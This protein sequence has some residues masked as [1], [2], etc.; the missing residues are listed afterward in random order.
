MDVTTT[1][2]RQGKFEARFYH[3]IFE[4]EIGR[5]RG[6]FG[7]VNITVF[8]TMITN[9]NLTVHSIQLQLILKARDMQ[10]EEKMATFAC[11]NSTRAILTSLTRSRDKPDNNSNS[12][13]QITLGLVCGAFAG[14][15]VLMVTKM[16]VEMLRS[17]SF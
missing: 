8:P 16:L 17:E 6:H 12:S 9:L 7:Y 10:V 5:V 13:S 15:K 1:S 4:E 3:K 2:T 11:I 14:V